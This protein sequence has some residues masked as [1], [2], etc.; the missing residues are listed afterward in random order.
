MTK[1]L[2][3]GILHFNVP[4]TLE[5]LH[6]LHR[7]LRKAHI[8]M[9]MNPLLSSIFFSG[10][11]ISP[12]APQKAMELRGFRT[13]TKILS[14]AV[15]AIVIFCGGLH[16]A[17]GEDR[18]RP[19]GPSIDDAELIINWDHYQGT[20][21]SVDGEFWC[22]DEHSCEFVPRPEL[23]RVVNV[24]IDFLPGGSKYDLVLYCHDACRLIIRGHVS[25]N[26]VMASD[27]F[28][29]WGNIEMRR[30]WRGVSAR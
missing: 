16:D 5:V 26:D 10:A 19:A 3:W 21:V 30:R 4:L 29:A 6:T 18:G 12:M 25:R 15:L 27:M 2:Y 20:T 7:F 24:N 11:P 13:L 23:G 28:D 1:M 14:I 9:P 22:L 17:S 8:A